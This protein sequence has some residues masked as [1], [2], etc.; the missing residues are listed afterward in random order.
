MKKPPA[1]SMHM[2]GKMPSRLT[3]R[4]LMQGTLALTAS[5]ML[6]LRLWADSSGDNPQPIPSGTLV[7]AT[8]KMSTT[9]QGA[10]GPCFAGLSYE[11]SELCQSYRIFSSQ[12]ADLI[13]LF[14]LIGPSILRIGGNSV[15]QN[16]WNPTGA[17]QT[18][19][20]IAPSDVEA[21]ASFLQATGWKCIY[22][23][24]LGGS[25]PYPY[26][27]GDFVASTTP[28][29]AAE[30]VN[31]VSGA[32][33]ASL[34][35]IEIGNEPNAYA[36]TYYQGTGWSVTAFQTVWQQ[37]YSAIIGQTPDV[38][39]T[40]PA[41]SSSSIGDWAEHFGNW[42]AN[43][44]I[45][46]ALLTHHYYIGDA[47]TSNLVVENSDGT[48]TCHPELMLA[49][50]TALSSELS[51]LRETTNSTGF[52]FRMAEC[53][54]YYGT[55]PDPTNTHPNPYH[56]LD[57]YAS[58]LWALDFL[59]DCAN[60]TSNGVNFHGGNDYNTYTPIAD[61]SGVVVGVRPEYY[62]ML[63][64]YLAGQG[65]TCKTIVSAGTL[66]VTAYT[67][68]T[69]SGLCLIVVNK[70]T[71]TNNA[72]TNLNLTIQTPSQF[73]TATLIELTQ[74]TAGNSGA[75]LGATDGITIQGS[76]VGLDGSF[77]LGAPYTLS[78]SGIYVQ[79]YVPALSAVLIQLT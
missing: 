64:F 37:F 55:V 7:D 62:G 4:K 42:A 16:V 33:G 21:L 44:S 54:T 77:T 69:A 18:P 25:G 70:D 12:N 27:D 65:A 31:Y 66:N 30:E 24:N 48:Y 78:P 29:L 58:A 68:Q 8:V 6:P 40:G 1:V 61:S 57:T 14:E 43:H 41:D 38:P 60:Y 49:P 50:D 22:G 9:S 79:C 47:A 19:G 67:V 75:D 72:G 36:N 45:P 74:L 63:M 34:V 2:S 71:G 39:I 20:Q 52:P 35:G 73:T 28:D 56:V 13:G 26:T 53:G 10:I 76:S 59:F 32:L 17:G 3:R 23:I 46:L 15:D 51:T 11:K 5:S